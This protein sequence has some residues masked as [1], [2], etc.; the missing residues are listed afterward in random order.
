MPYVPHFWLGVALAEQE[1][2]DA[3]MRELSASESDGIVQ[4]TSHYSRLRSTKSKIDSKRASAISSVGLEEARKLA[5]AALGEALASQAAATRAGAARLTEFRQANQKLQDALS[6]RK[7]GTVDGYRA[8][9]AS[10]GQAMILFNQAAAKVGD[11]PNGVR[12]KPQKE[13]PAAKRPPAS[14]SSPKPAAPQPE[15]VVSELQVVEERRDPVV[16]TPAETSASSRPSPPPNP[17]P[18]IVAETEVDRPE[19]E[20]A[21]I[22]QEEERPADA[23]EDLVRIYRA[24]AGGDLDGSSRSLTRILETDPRSLPAL[25]LRGYARYLRGTLERRESLLSDAAEDFRAALAIEPALVLD[26][27]DFSPKAIR[28]LESVRNGER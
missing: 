16:A 28:F 25:V 1:R 22:T 6:S 7:D 18:A 26:E 3:A 19:T 27:R 4:N 21:A 9:A 20:S 14:A 8:M 11:Q 10:A 24:M 17:A 12:A 15:V 13:T 5:D 2:W 23:R